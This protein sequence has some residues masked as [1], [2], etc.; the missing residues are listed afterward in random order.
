MFSRYNPAE[1]IPPPFEADLRMQISMYN[2]E[3]GPSIVRSVFVY[4]NSSNGFWNS[5]V[6]AQLLAAKEILALEDQNESYVCY[7]KEP[8]LLANGTTSDYYECK[9]CKACKEG[10]RV[11]ARMRWLMVD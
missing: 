7:H 1:S 3:R 9:A 8:K 2:E 10:A 4:R 11:V 5:Q 6:S